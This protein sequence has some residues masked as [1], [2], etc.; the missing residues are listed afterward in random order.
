[1]P[2][3][4]QALAVR[5]TAVADTT[6]RVMV[7]DDSAVIRGLISRLLQE[8][9]GIRV[10]TTASNGEQAINTLRRSSVDVIV[11]DIEMPVMDGLT[12]LPRLLKVDPDVKIIIASTLST[13]NAEISIRC[14]N[15]GAADYVP[16][17]TAVRDISGGVGGGDSFRRELLE[18][19]RALGD[20]C[21]QARTG[22]AGERPVRTV[23]VGPARSDAGP[24]G[25]APFQLAAPG[26][27]PPAVLA[28]GTSTGGPQAL[29]KFLGGLS[30]NI[31]LPILIVQHMPATFTSILA[32]HIRKQT[33]L[34]CA[35]GRD[36]EAVVPGRIY[37]APGDYHMVVEKQGVQRI[38]RLNQMP[39]ENFCRPAV[40]PLFRSLA[41]TYGAPVLGIV[42]TGLGSDGLKGGE[43]ICRA[44]G[45]VVA[46]DEATSVVWG[47]PGAVA[48]AGLC[49]AVLPLTDLAPF[50]EDFV[51]GRV[52]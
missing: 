16:K 18:K 44:G 30:R 2:N 7:V 50:V 28:I 15:A 52:T 17:P 27:K 47:M 3:P 34:E 49:S 6:V 33:G 24:A 41:E 21:V 26:R 51:G 45:T 9:P 35:E 42:L 46:Q 38:I 29:F 48:R 39:P 32:D 20:A 36:G 43:V 1:M 23:A 40:D 14:L 11:L 10:V 37:L 22:D 12:A 13:R 25:T 5:P 4:S 19:V 31:S 8:D